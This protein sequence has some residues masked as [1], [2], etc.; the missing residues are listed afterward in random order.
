[1]YSTFCCLA[2]VLGD[3]L[4]LFCGWCIYHVTQFLRLYKDFTRGVLHPH[5]QVFTNY[6]VMIVLKR[7]L[8]GLNPGTSD[9]PVISNNRPGEYVPLLTKT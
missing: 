1:M 2:F 7:F 3:E 6:I 5:A 8:I 9:S 4:Q